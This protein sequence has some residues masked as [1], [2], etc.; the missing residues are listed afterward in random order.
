[1]GLPQFLDIEFAATATGYLPTAMAWS[2]AD[3]RMKTV[4]VTPEDDWL[5]EDP[6]DHDLD[7]AYLQ[8]QGAPALDIVQEMSE[9]LGDTTVFVDGLDPDEAVLEWFFESLGR[10]LPF[11]V[12]TVDQ[13]IHH[14]DSDTLE[15]WRRE[16]MITHGLEP[17]LPESGVYALL[18][19]AREAGLVPGMEPGEL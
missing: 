1:M 9:D 6:D 10:P 2:L 17:Q 15:D 16:L 18:L 13:L 19:L 7:L 5:P 8:E 12:A 3:G 4:V 11:E 14:L